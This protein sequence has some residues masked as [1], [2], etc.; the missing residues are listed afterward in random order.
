MKKRNWAQAGSLTHQPLPPRVGLEL[1]SGS[2]PRHYDVVWIPKQHLNHYATF[3]CSF[4]QMIILLVTEFR[5][6]FFLNKVLLGHLL[7]LNGAKEET[8]IDAADYF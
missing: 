2:E 4:F 6:N 8:D 7:A 3:L 5:F 1:E